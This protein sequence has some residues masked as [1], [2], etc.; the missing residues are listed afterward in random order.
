MVEEEAADEKAVLCCR[1]DGRSYRHGQHQP[2]RCGQRRRRQ[3]Q[4]GEMAA[5]TVKAEGL[6]ARDAPLAEGARPRLIIEK[7]VT[8]NFKSYAEIQ[9]IGPFHEVRRR[10]E[11]GSLR[12]A[13]RCAV[14]CCASCCII[15]LCAV[16]IAAELFGDRGAERQREV[17]RHRRVAVRVWQARQADPHVEGARACRRRSWTLRGRQSRQLT[18]F[19]AAAF[20]GLGADPQVGRAPGLHVCQG[21]RALQG[22]ARRGAPARAMAGAPPSP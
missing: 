18:T 16:R 11:S 17:Q 9:T 13:A 12:A 15:A 7:L 8:Q 14:E 6:P 20:A 5:E 10:S 1:A 19:G 2:E 22:C 3:Q 21:R 4:L